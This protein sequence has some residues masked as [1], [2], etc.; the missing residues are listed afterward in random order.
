MPTW[1]SK[2]NEIPYGAGYPKV[3]VYAKV[4]S[5]NCEPKICNLI[6]IQHSNLYLKIKQKTNLVTTSAHVRQLCDLLPSE[7]VKKKYT[8][9]IVEKF[10]HSS[11]SS[12]YGMAELF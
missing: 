4:I 8:S 10:C 6:G 12:F 7:K 5:T 2:N 11:S 3:H 1:C 9:V